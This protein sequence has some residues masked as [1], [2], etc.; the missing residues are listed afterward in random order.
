VPF[1][2]ISGFRCENINIKSSNTPWYK[3]G[4][5]LDELNH[6]EPPK[7]A[8]DKPLRIPLSS[9]HTIKGVGT[10][11]VGKIESGT[12]KPGMTLRFAGVGLTDT[13]FSIETHH[14]SVPEAKA[15]D[16]VGFKLPRL[17][18]RQLARGMVASD[19]KICP[20]RRVV[21]FRARIV[22]QRKC[23]LHPG[24]MPVMDCHTSHVTC[25]ITTFLEKSN[26]R[27]N[28]KEKAPKLLINGDCA[29]VIMVPQKPMCLESYS[30]F[31]QLGRF[32]LRDMGRFIVA[33]G[34]VLDVEFEP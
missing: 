29:E 10:V 12:L 11:A 3:G 32:L 15:G 30:D 2:P 33:V 16:Y 1:I 5:L 23:K 17:L 20:A 9:V 27:N 4:T 28:T 19:A 31:P 13:C 6:L 7:I 22:V 24:F 25:K 26:Q 34:M 8:V 18:T 14:R 21:S